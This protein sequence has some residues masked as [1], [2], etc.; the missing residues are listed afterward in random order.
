[1]NEL[2][3]VRHGI[4]VPY[5]TIGFQDDERPLTPKGERRMRQIGRGLSA[6]GLG[7]ELDRIVTSPL[8][9]A[10]RTAQILAAELH[11][12]DHLE[13]STTLAADSDAQTIAD[14]LRERTEDRLMIVGHNPAL[15]DLVGLLTLGEAGMFPFDLK[16]GGLAALSAS[17]RTSLRFQL[18]WTAPPALLRRL[19][20]A[21]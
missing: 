15:S 9:R 5:G 2:Y 18:N 11:L 14:W 20:E 21:K 1:M 10:R 16:K 3:I 12:V 4:A 19:A 7:L 13:V 17:L 6:L 8:P